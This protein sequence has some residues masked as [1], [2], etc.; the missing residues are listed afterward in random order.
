LDQSLAQTQT[1]AVARGFIIRPNT[2]KPERIRPPGW[3]RLR[4]ESEGIISV[5]ASFFDGLQQRIMIADRTYANVQ[6]TNDWVLEEGGNKAT[7][8]LKTLQ[9]WTNTTTTLERSDL[10]STKTRLEPRTQSIAYLPFMVTDNFTTARQ[11]EY[12]WQVLSD[13][14]HSKLTPAIQWR[15]KCVRNT[16]GQ[17]TNGDMGESCYIVF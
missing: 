10:S 8:F 3:S 13:I 15:T 17:G 12:I 14:W 7:V 11:L 2:A 16:P 1:L 9:G 4:R 6:R 5:D